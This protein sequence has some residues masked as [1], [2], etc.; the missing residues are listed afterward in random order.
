MRVC[1]GGVIR[2]ITIGVAAPDTGENSVTRAGRAV[3]RS[4][5]CSH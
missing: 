3:H 2:E 1:A 5:G 4:P